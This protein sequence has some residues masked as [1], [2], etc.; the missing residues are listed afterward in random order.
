MTLEK[1]S[2]SMYMSVS[3]M[4]GVR[5]EATK[6]S[7]PLF[8]I[9]FDSIFQSSK[10]DKFATD[11]QIADTKQTGYAYK[12][13]LGDAVKGKDAESGKMGAVFNATTPSTKPY[14]FSFVYHVVDD[15]S[16]EFWFDVG[17]LGVEEKDWDTEAAYISLCW[18]VSRKED[19]SASFVKLKAGEVTTEENVSTLEFRN[20]TSFSIKLDNAKTATGSSVGAHMGAHDELGCFT[21]KKF[22]GD[23]WHSATVSISGSNTHTASLSTMIVYTSFTTLVTLLFLFM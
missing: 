4:S 16:E 2:G 19:E 12:F 8:R 3:T 1:D 22:N 6:Y 20:G 5:T 23:L 14:G 15:G 13:D 11:N 10:L 7:Y 18:T 21:Y 17:M 9:D